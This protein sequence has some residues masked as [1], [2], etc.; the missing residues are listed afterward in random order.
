MLSCENAYYVVSLAFLS[1]L[2][3][4]CGGGTISE[5]TEI[6]SPPVSN[7]NLYFLAC[8]GGLSHCKVIHKLNSIDIIL[9]PID[10][11]D[12]VVFILSRGDQLFLL[13]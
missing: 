10:C 11:C 7:A 1:D 4:G 2:A 6:M 8:H 13:P 5:D 12:I 3:Q 9:I